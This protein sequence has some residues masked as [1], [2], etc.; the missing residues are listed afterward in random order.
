[1]DWYV[2]REKRDGTHEADIIY[3][4]LSEARLALELSKTELGDKVFIVEPIMNRFRF[5]V[6]PE[7]GGGRGGV[8]LGSERAQETVKTMLVRGLSSELKRAEI[9][10]HLERLL[11][12]RPLIL[13]LYGKNILRPAIDIAVDFDSAMA[14]V[15]FASRSYMLKA[16]LTLRA[17]P[18]EKLECIIAPGRHLMYVLL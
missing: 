10:D 4:N 15:E 1:V 5:N 13:A 16:M 11:G 8:E 3:A 18:K 12:E 17:L 9:E 2:S 7:M 6:A 14:A